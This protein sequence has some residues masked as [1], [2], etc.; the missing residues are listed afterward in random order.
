VSRAHDDAV[1]ARIREIP[2]LSEV[3][4]DGDVEGHPTFYVN[5]HM[6]RPVETA[7]R[8]AGLARSGTK[9]YWIHSVGASRRLASSVA[10]KV[11]A[12]LLNWAPE[13][14]GF[15]PRRMTH[16]T[17]QPTQKNETTKPPIFFAV[18]VFDVVIDPTDP[19]P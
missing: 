17:S 4:F 5:V 3:V 1:L 19:T 11:V 2:T 9:T 15:S 10:E 16:P 8:F 7:D 12:K 6:N 18:D 14:D 13:V